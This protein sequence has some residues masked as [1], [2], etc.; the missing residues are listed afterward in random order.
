MNRDLNKAIKDAH[1]K[2]IDAESSLSATASSNKQPD[3]QE[4][5]RQ[6]RFQIG[7]AVHEYESNLAMLNCGVSNPTDQELEDARQGKEWY[8]SQIAISH[9][10]AANA[11]VPLE[12]MLEYEQQCKE[13]Y[14]EWLY[15]ELKNLQTVIHSDGLITVT[16]TRTGEV[17]KCDNNFKPID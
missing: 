1:N 8:E 11:N 15:A 6:K 3:S 9:Q 4:Q 7:R 17:L 12:E 2:I 14:E 13:Q 16:N 10:A 5:L